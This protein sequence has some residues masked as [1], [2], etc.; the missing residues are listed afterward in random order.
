MIGSIIGLSEL[1]VVERGNIHFVLNEIPL[2]LSLSC[3]CSIYQPLWQ[4]YDME[5]HKISNP[6]NGNIK[7]M[8]ATSGDECDEDTAYLIEPN[9]D[10]YLEANNEFNINRSMVIMCYSS[11]VREAVVFKIPGTSV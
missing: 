8:N 10:I 6:F 5:L 3:R 9:P 4:V 1:E 7:C 2:Q 11:L